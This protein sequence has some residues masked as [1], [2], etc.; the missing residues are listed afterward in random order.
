MFES[1]P[2]CTNF[3]VFASAAT[4][5]PATGTRIAKDQLR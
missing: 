4:C 5:V 1:F 3:T 2:R